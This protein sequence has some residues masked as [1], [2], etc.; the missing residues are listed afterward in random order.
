MAGFSECPFL[1]GFVHFWTLTFQ[2]IPGLVY[3]GV[4]STLLIGIV[5]TSSFL[6]ARIGLRFLA[7]LL[8]IEYIFLIYCSTVIFRDI[9]ETPLYKPIS[10][11]TYKD[12]FERE[13]M[14]VA[15]EIF[16]NVLFFVPIG[17]LL[18][19]ASKCMKWW[20]V[21]LTGCGISISIELLQYFLKR[22]TMEVVDVILNSLGCTIGV[23]IVAIIEEIWLLKRRYLMK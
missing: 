15:P 16:F 14:H 21:L 2:R 19:G 4:L 10:F 22:G 3:E 11:D 18:C 23:M 1:K 12:I 7:N 9:K 17:I 8:L 6:K 20:H 13:G 5:L